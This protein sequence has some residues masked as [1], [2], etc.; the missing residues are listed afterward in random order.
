MIY[1]QIIHIWLILNFITTV[2]MLYQ[3]SIALEAFKRNKKKPDIEI[4]YH[5]F[6]AL[7]AARNEE[8]VIET[9]IKSIRQQN[10]PEELID[11]IVIADNCDDKTAEISEK[12][13]AIVYERFNKLQI[14][15][16][17]VIKFVL[18][19]IFAQRDIYDAFCI[20]DADNV[21]DRDFFMHMN[22]ALCEG[23]NVAQGYRDM[24]NPTDNWISGGHALF[25][26]ME[27]RFFDYA[28]AELGLSAMLNGTAI[29]ITR[30][31][32]RKFGYDMKT[33]TEDVELTIQ[34]VINGEKV[35]WVPQAKVYD[36]Q[37]LTLKQSMVQ[38]SRWVS[39]FIQNTGKYFKAFVESIYI[40]T[41]WIKIDMF[42]FIASLP[43]MIL[44]LVSI[45]LYSAL[46]VF[47]IFDMGST[48]INLLILTAG[49][50]AVFWGIGFLSVILEGKKIRGMIK[51]ILMNP[52]FN[53]TWALIWCKCVFV[54]SHEW[55]PIT[56]DRNISIEEIEGTNQK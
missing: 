26:W 3:L 33:V 32:I 2:F 4:K 37:P 38:R 16:G 40:K 12:A 52:I 10:Y 24:K 50:V 43:L 14:G 34:C 41:T 23:A 39:G 20:F 29:M 44:G 36:E 5:R 47:N 54:H 53:L 45:V 35:E 51:A 55:T 21:V 25:Y 46:T 13:G 42:L 6:A 48:L 28:R 27:N 49:A 17:Y 56:H 30:E 31:Y 19:K 11:I 22:R 8:L 1:N 18:E 9:L 15:K 7:I